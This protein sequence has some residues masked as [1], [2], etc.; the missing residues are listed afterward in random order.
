MRYKA[1]IFDFDGLMFDTEKIWKKFF[2]KGNKKFK[3]NLIEKDRLELIGK[4]EEAVRS[5]M[6]EKFPTLDVATYRDWIRGHAIHSLLTFGAKKKKGLKE[7]LKFAKSKN[8]LCGIAS[9]SE[10]EVITKIMDKAKVDVNI[11]STFACGDMKIKPK[12]NPDVFLKVCKD[13]G[14]EPNEAIVLEDSYN[15]V[16]AGKRAGCF[17]IMIPDTAPVTQEM[18]DTADLILNNLKEAVGFLQNF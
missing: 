8:L 2:H 4:N 1:I 6:L 9:G 12:P 5:H 15:G 3:V 14:V 10:K 17:T 13:L 11:F 7:I 18:K 16:R